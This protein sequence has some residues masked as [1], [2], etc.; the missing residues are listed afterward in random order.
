MYLFTRDRVGKVRRESGRKRKFW[1]D[2]GRG[3]I[4]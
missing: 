1:E 3:K 2:N 4:V